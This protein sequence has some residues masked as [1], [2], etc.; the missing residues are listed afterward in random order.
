MGGGRNFDLFISVG[1]RGSTRIIVEFYEVQLH[2]YNGHMPWKR[3][4]RS[5]LK[6]STYCFVYIKC[7]AFFQIHTSDLDIIAKN[8]ERLHSQ[9]VFQRQKTSS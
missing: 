2:H 3:Y 1:F 6:R 7:F 8:E 9:P 5:N 4:D